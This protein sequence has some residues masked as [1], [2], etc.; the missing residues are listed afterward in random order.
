MQTKGQLVS[1][2]TEDGIRLS[3]F[4][5]EGD[6]SKPALLHV[7]GFEQKFHMNEFVRRIGDLTAQN[8][9]A[10][11]TIET[12]G[13]GKSTSFFTS[14]SGEV[15]NIGGDFELLEEAH[16]DIDA[17]IDFLKAQG[18]KSVVLEG[19][20]LGTN[21]ITRY[22]SEGKN[23][24]FVKALI[25]IDSFEKTALIEDYSKGKWRDHLKIAQEM[26]KNGRG[27][28]MV[29]IE[30]EE[31]TISY[32]TYHSWYVDNDITHTFD[33][34]NEDYDFPIL[35]AI[36]IPVHF[37]IGS[38]DEFFSMSAKGDYRNK[39]DFVIKQLQK[40]SGDIID[41]GRHDLIGVEDDVAD[42]VVGYLKSII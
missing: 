32:Q 22:L 31:L 11:L 5:I 41:G 18:Y 12:R 1:T 39:L 4:Y 6:R 16:Y 25:C 36:K 20:S 35:R 28:E 29:P 15:R 27:D 40:G 7:H 9:F 2:E 30:F 21:K 37:I 23:T 38:E 24:E 14:K 34:D 13:S 17:W 19:H 3:A 26:I 8:N 42:S 10:F 33:V